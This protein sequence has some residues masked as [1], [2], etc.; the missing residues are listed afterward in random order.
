MGAKVI[1]MARG[2]EPIV[3]GSADPRGIMAR[4]LARETGTSMLAEI[5]GVLVEW[6]T[7]GSQSPS[8]GT[9]GSQMSGRMTRKN[10]PMIVGTK[11][12][13]TEADS[14]GAMR[15]AYN[16]HRSVTSQP[17]SAIA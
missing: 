17:S 8:G 7:P 5:R 13:P 16:S 14:G 6:R 1:G 11:A 2:V 3:N 9:G 15:G 12:T 4:M 10:G